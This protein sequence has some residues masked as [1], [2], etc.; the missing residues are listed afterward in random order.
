MSNLDTISDN[1]CAISN[2]KNYI[3]C[4]YPNF[5]ILGKPLKT[6]TGIKYEQK[7]YFKIRAHDFES[8][9]HHLN[10]ALE[11]FSS[12]VINVLNETILEEPGLKYSIHCVIVNDKK[13][14]S[15]EQN[16]NVNQL[17]FKFDLCELKALLLA[18]ADLIMHTFCLEDNVLIIFYLILN[19]FLCLN[20]TIEKVSKKI[21]N[22]KYS[23][24]FSLCQITCNTNQI[25]GS[26]FL[27]TEYL[28]KHKLHLLIIYH[29]KR[30]CLLPVPNLIQ[31]YQQ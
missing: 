11:W 2:L 13:E 30:T 22:L 19:H 14:L 12:N 28:L 31:K 4:A 6:L 16:Q 9:F 5:L 15:I 18:F 29:L 17:T 10:S 20:W 27:F 21:A 8:W 24:V 23:D 1:F 7:T 26:I 3:L 25:E